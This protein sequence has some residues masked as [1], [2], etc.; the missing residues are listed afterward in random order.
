MGQ[1]ASQDARQADERMAATDEAVILGTVADHFAVDA[2]YGI[3]QANR[4]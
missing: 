2:E 3:L 4:I 1:W